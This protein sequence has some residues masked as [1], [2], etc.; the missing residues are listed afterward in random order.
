MNLE[1]LRL[2]Y[3]LAGLTE[4]SMHPDPYEQ[5]RTWFAQAR[6]TSAPE[7]NAM[8]L[9]TVDKDGVPSARIVLL[10]GVEEDGFVFYTNYESQKGRE[11][12]ENP[13]A[14]L[15]FYW[16]ELERQVRIAGTVEKVSREKSDAYFQGRPEG[17]KLGAWVSR[18]STVVS[19]REELEQKLAER[20][21][22]FAGG[23][24]PTPPHWGGYCLKPV[25][26]E[27]WQ[28]RPNRLHDRLRYRRTEDGWR[29]ERLAP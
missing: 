20:E 23:P 19:G 12:A 1:E 21:K 4:A 14:A 11:L 17:S 26:I 16:G 5:F 29:L 25:E 3:T 27:F 2:N 9:A 24:I 15:V 22:E 18:Q 13:H 28:G 7:P 8:T 10:K 6:E